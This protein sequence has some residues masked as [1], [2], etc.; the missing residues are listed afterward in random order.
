MSSNCSRAA[1]KSEFLEACRQTE[2]EPQPIEVTRAVIGGRLVA[3]NAAT[4]AVL[5]DTYSTD[6][7]EWVRRHHPSI[8]DDHTMQEENDDHAMQPEKDDHAL[9]NAQQQ[10]KDDHA[11]GNAQQQEK[12]DRALGHADDDDH[13]MQNAEND[14]HAIG[15]ADEPQQ[16]DQQQE[17]NDHTMDTIT[18]SWTAA[19]DSSS[20]TYPDVHK[21]CPGCG[22]DELQLKQ[23]LYDDYRCIECKFGPSIQGR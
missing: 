20:G 9:G 13:T 11:I 16:D 21:I 7:A 3:L 17:T 5:P 4:G 22:R 14:D 15:H 10:E 23:K 1:S 12:D 8:D 18:M 6:F 19:S 2:A